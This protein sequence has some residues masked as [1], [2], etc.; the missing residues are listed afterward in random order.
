MSAH[1][2]GRTVSASQD[3]AACTAPGEETPR[4]AAALAAETEIPTKEGREVLLCV[5]GSANTPARG[6][7]PRHA[8]APRAAGA[9]HWTKTTV[10]A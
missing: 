7:Q 3:R 9:T 4:T 5:D 1:C 8:L 10:R 2:M 6:R